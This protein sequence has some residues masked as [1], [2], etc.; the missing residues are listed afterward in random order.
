[1]Q[2]C[3]GFPCESALI[4]VPVLYDADRAVEAHAATL[5][6]GASLEFDMNFGA[7]LPSVGD[8]AAEHAAQG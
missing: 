4:V 7:G 3:I 2:H 8:D 1:M 5:P 6:A